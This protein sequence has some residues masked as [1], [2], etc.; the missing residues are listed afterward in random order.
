MRTFLSIL[1]ILSRVTYLFLSERMEVSEYSVHAPRMIDTCVVNAPYPKDLTAVVALIVLTG[2][3][4][5]L[6]EV[7]QSTK[8]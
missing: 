2:I 8:V 6:I 7:T 3:L 5:V 4:A 1:C